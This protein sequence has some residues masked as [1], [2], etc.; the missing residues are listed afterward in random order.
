MPNK[1]LLRILHKFAQQNAN[2]GH[3]EKMKKVEFESKV[4][5]LNEQRRLHFYEV[6]AHNLTVS[7]RSVWSNKDI[8]DTEKVDRIKWINEILHRVTAKVWVLRLHT[9]EWSE[10]DFASEI[11]HWVSQNSEIECEVDWAVN[12]SLRSVTCN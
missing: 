10:T 7:I 5:A 9:H 4:F 1:A 8:T 6:L 12:T 11:A 3:G 2:F